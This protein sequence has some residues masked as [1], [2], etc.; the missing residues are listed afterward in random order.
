ML[1]GLRNVSQKLKSINWLFYVFYISKNILPHLS[2]NQILRFRRSCSRIKGISDDHLRCHPRPRSQNYI[3]L[4]SSFFD[5]SDIQ[6]VHIETVLDDTYL[7]E[8]YT[9]SHFLGKVEA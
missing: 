3:R 5:A 4:F 2:L 8:T 9:L 7:G 6:F 1:K